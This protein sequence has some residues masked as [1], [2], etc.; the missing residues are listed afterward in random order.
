MAS[1]AAL[2]QVRP[3]YYPGDPAI[4]PSSDIATYKTDRDTSKLKIVE[5]MQPM[6]FHVGP[7]LAEHLITTLGM[8]KENMSWQETFDLSLFVASKTLK[9]VLNLEGFDEV[10][11]GAIRALPL[12]VIIWLGNIG[13]EVSQSPLARRIENAPV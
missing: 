11:E 2:N 13:L 8:I 9:R 7:M 6:E 10:T 5:G 12:E 4:D 3:Y 1:L